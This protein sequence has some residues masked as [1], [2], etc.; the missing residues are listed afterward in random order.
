MAFLLA[1]S[2]Q[3]E[4]I[5]GVLFN[6]VRLVRKGACEITALKYFVFQLDHTKFGSFDSLNDQSC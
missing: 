1:A 3:A 6:L 4:L 2:R 5:Q